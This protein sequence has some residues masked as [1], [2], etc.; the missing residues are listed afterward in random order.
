MNLIKKTFAKEL[1]NICNDNYSFICNN[2]D[3]YIAKYFSWDLVV[4]QLIKLIENK[5]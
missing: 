1:I 2:I 5:L 3:T 4:K